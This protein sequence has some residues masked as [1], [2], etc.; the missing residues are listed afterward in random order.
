MSRNGLK[1]YNLVLPQDLF[2]EIKEVADN[3]GTTVVEVIR[4]F[5]KLGL[6]AVKI[7][8]EP[9]SALIIREGDSEQQLLIL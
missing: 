9:G 1:R 3:E 8:N 5:V 2:D 4:K 7:Q 6:I